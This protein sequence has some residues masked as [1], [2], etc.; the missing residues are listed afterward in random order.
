MPMSHMEAHNM[1]GETQVS[2]TD[3]LAINSDKM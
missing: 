2:F 1:S 3:Y